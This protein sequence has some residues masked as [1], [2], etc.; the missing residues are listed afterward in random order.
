M[1]NARG[2]L[3]SQVGPWQA[4]SRTCGGG[5][6]E[7]VVACFDVRHNAK[8]VNAYCKRHVAK[9]KHLL[10]CNMHNCQKAKWLYGEWTKC[11]VTCGQVR[12][13]ANGGASGSIGFCLTAGYSDAVCELRERV[14]W[15]AAGRGVV[16]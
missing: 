16:R 5:L 8:V 7:R 14:E 11:P 13:E 1:L 12:R 10:H 9:P 2:L 6:S 15:P 3:N 4:C